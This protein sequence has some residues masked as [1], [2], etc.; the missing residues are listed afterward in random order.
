[1]KKIIPITDL[2]R[3]AGQVVGSLSDSDEPVVVTQRGRAAAVIVSVERYQQIEADLERLD[4]LELSEMV[5][6]GRAAKAAGEVLSHAEVKRRL[7]VADVRADAP[8]HK[9][10]AKRGAKRRRQA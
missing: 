1:M 4:E 6:R 9:L 3:Q 8:A 5:E 2:Q 7:G 10:T